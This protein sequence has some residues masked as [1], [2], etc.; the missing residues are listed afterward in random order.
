M[1][2]DKNLI[3]D[4]MKQFEDDE[5]QAVSAASNTLSEN[6]EP[7]QDATAVSESDCPQDQEVSTIQQSSK[8]EN[9]YPQT[10]LAISAMN[11]VTSATCI[12]KYVQIP[13]YRTYAQVICDANCNPYLCIP[14][15]QTNQYEPYGM[16]V[17]E[18][19]GEYAVYQSCQKVA[20][21]CY[22]SFEDP[23]WQFVPLGAAMQ[24][25]KQSYQYPIPNAGQ[26]KYTFNNVPPEQA[27]SIIRN[28]ME[29]QPQNPVEVNF[30]SPAMKS[31]SPFI[32]V[33]EL[34][35]I[36]DILPE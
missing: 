10:N 19:S 27:D 29:N 5:Q 18:P 24:Q 22:H 11:A 33:D 13:N 20:T 8:A 16:I 34:K 28:V 35:G 9:N 30:A 3:S 12:G 7:V 25:P 1:P 6:I 2:D 14:N 31:G 17:F 4:F 36:I 15:Q 21:L 26:I 23:I 32:S